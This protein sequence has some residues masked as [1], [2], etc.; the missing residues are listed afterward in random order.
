M[1]E[2]KDAGFANRGTARRWRE[3]DHLGFIAKPYSDIVLRFRP[4]RTKVLW[5]NQNNF[6][7][8]SRVW[9]GAEESLLRGG[10]ERNG[11]IRARDE[12]MWGVT[13]FPCQQ[14][15]YGGAGVRFFML[16]SEE[17]TRNSRHKLT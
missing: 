10:G 16:V 4:L 1:D 2:I 14:G 3:G 12:K 6:R 8:G 13:P 15:G 17:R 11:L 9:P 7:K 5:Y